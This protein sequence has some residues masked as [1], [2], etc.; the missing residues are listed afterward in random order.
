MEHIDP[1][2]LETV[3]KIAKDNWKKF[4]D[5]PVGFEVEITC[6]LLKLKNITATPIDKNN[7]YLGTHLDIEFEKSTLGAHF[8]I[9]FEKSTEGENT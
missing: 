3:R 8:D 2:I 5:K 1:K 6:P 9:E 4:Q 7:P